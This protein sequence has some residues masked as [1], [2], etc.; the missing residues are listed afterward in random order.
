MNRKKRLISLYCFLYYLVLPSAASSEEKICDQSENVKFVINEIFQSEDEDAIFIHDWANFFHIK[1]KQ[2]TISNESA[3]FL[4]KCQ[5]NFEDLQELERHLRAKKYIR[6]SSVKFTDTNSINVETWDNWSLSPTVGFGRKGGKT[7]SAIGIKDRNLLGLG[8][9]AEIEYFSNDQRSGY[10]FDTQFPLFLKRNIKAN[11]RFTN[12]NDGASTAAFLRKDFVSFDTRNSYE[13]GFD[14]FSQIDTQYNGG[15]EFNKY[16]HKRRFSTASWHWLDND[17]SKKTVRFGI[18]VTSEKHTFYDIRNAVEQQ[19]KI[20]PTDRDFNYVFASIKYLNKDY[21]KLSNFNLINQIEDFNIGWDMSID[22]GTDISNNRI[23]P[24]F[25]WRSTIKKGLDIFDN[26][27]L[28]FDAKFEGEFYSADKGDNNRFLLTIDSEYFSKI[29]ERWSGYFKNTSR[30]SQ[31]QFLDSPVVFGG[32]T[33][34]RGFPLQY[35]RGKH[36]TSFTFEARY[37]PHINIYKLIELGGAI[38]ID[39]GKVF[40]QSNFS[41]KQSP[42]ITSFGLGARFYSTHSSEGQVIHV[43]LIKPITSDPNVNSIELRISTKHSF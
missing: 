40:G 29:N 21:R 14:N 19:T 26:D 25:L 36:S 33:G 1:T 9:D 6:D 18:G 30:F 17:T 38:F 32:E 22:L 20:L 23:S 24:S 42:W 3:F 7:K 43:D 2:I 34:M 27:L 35:Q 16:I 15:I 39:S 5:L 11:L 12:N 41:N 37:Y 8:I 10:K 28:F 31:N 4:K 13:I